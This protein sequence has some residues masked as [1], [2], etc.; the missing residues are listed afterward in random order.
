MNK[1]L[2]KEIQ[3][4]T[5][6]QNS[7]PL[8]E[9]D[10]LI[11]VNDENMN[12]VY[13]II[14]PPYD[15]VYRHKFIRLDFDIPNEYPYH[16]PKVTFVNYDYVRIHPNFYE[17]GRCC[18]TI[19][20]SWPSAE[21]DGIKLE[22][23]SSSMG[24]ETILLTFRSFL[25]NNPYTH[26]PGGKD[27]ISY[28]NYVLY[29]TWDTC[30]LKYVNKYIYNSQPKLFLDYINEYIM[31]NVSSIFNDLYIL[32]D[33]FPFGTY[34]TSCFYI[35][36]YFINYDIIISCLDEY[37]TSCHEQA[38]SQ[39]GSIKDDPGFL[40]CTDPTRVCGSGYE[41]NVEQDVKMNRNPDNCND[42]NLSINNN[43]SNVENNVSTV[44]NTFINNESQ[45]NETD[46]YKYIQNENVFKETIKKEDNEDIIKCQIC[47]DPVFL[48]FCPVQTRTE[49]GTDPNRGRY[50]SERSRDAVESRVDLNNA[51]KLIVLECNHFFHRD[52][53]KRHILHNGQLC[54]FCRCRTSIDEWIIN[55]QTNKK[56]KI[57]G[58]TYK[59]LIQE[60]IDV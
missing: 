32:K 28:T 12:K 27:D 15:S 4:L 59:K 41:Q 19:L 54:S 45:N 26:E 57:D 3:R 9:N 13:T 52:C 36:D 24:I 56:I 2:V 5:V 31:E 20:N 8:L 18:S 30:L 51:Q 10:Y 47:F 58:M 44:T 34:H 11:Y 6:E 21:S 29:Q 46:L 17:D 55:P 49:V 53:I 40:S 33:L 37:I 16:P 43:N 25:D 1:R 60:G 35:Y 39:L 22:A 7:R 50:R 14:K 42:I 38:Q 23:W 48:S